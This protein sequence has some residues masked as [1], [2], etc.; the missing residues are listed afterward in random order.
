MSDRRPYTTRFAPSPTGR[1]HLGHAYAALVASDMATASGGTFLLRIEDI[2]GR[3]ARPE[4]ERGI[5]DDLKWLG[6][7]WPG[8]IMRQSERM[9]A[10]GVAIA[11]LRSRDLI[12]PC[13]C[14]RKDIAAEIGA[15]GAAPHATTMGPDGP[16]Y[17][18][19]CKTM[20][21]GERRRRIAA[22]DAH[23]LRLHMDRA[24]NLIN[25]PLVF[26]ECAEG[27]NGESGTITATP[28]IFGDVVLARKEV[29]TSYHLAVVV[30]DA[31]QGVTLV[32]RGRD[33]FPSTHLHRL[34]QA[35][36]DVPTPAYLHHQ[37]I[38]DEN[39]K[40]LAKR[41]DALSLAAL[42]ESGKSPADIRR[43][44]PDPTSR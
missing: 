10:Y 27:M 28:E 9:K 38:C 1:L 25:G 3:R 40:R 36:L 26:Q 17:P 19:I 6:L 44:L 2:D 33:I 32:T 21:P 39:G 13:F 5:F 18:G 20:S 15:S 34:L 30:D 11:A 42:R 43:M 31:A 12:Y 41:N 29:A 7:S 35:L 16:I 37:L 23:A 22:G 8:P 4:F 14:T 24:L